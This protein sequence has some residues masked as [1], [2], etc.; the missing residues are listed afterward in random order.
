MPKATGGATVKVHYTGRLEDGT[1]FDQSSKDE[2]LT[3]TLGTGQVIAGFEE[4][5]LGMEPGAEKSTVVSPD[6]GYGP[7]RQALVGTVERARVPEEIDLAIGKQ[8]RVRQND[9]VEHA[10]T[11]VDVTD[12]A[13]TLDAN[14]PLAGKTL[15][16]DVQLLEVV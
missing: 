10:V 5:I 9:G 4:A 11:V 1:I 14:H 8:L 13:V 12:E 15:T 16:F 7:H 6:K 2:P 3:I